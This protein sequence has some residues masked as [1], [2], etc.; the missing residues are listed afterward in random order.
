MGWLARLFGRSGSS[1]SASH[2]FYVYLRCE[3]TRYRPCGEPICVRIDLRNDLNPE[4][5]AEGEDRPSGYVCYKDVLGSWCQQM[6]R[7][8]LRYDHARREIERSVEGAT[9]IGQ[10]EYERLKREADAPPEA[11]R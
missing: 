5:D 10:E 2:G 3:G 6:V 7:L 1:S 9:F 11:R 8:T 4:Y